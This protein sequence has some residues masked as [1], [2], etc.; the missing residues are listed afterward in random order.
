MHEQGPILLLTGPPGAGKTTVARLL[1]SQARRAVHLESD[2]FFHFIR[3]GYINPWRP[4][5]DQQNATVMRLIGEVA[6]GYARAGYFTIV[7]GIFIPGWFLE[8]V[9]DALIRSG[10]TV[11]YAVLR[12]PLAVCQARAADRDRDPLRDPTAVEQLWNAF[13]DLG[14]LERHSV[15][16][17][18]ADPAAVADLIAR[19]LDQ[20]RTIRGPVAVRVR[21]GEQSDQAFVIQMGRLACSLD[22]RPVPPSDDLAVGALLPAS[23]EQTVIAV[24]EKGRPI[25]AAWWHMHQPALLSDVSGAPL[26]ELAMGVIESERGRGIGSTLIEELAART[27]L[28]FEA[29]AANVHLLNPAVRLYIRTG[30]RVAGQGRGHYGVAMRRRLRHE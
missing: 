13:A 30:F 14:D 10:N 19:E 16:T 4:E 23:A 29:L 17:D 2:E 3:S 9:R 11:A 7:D 12:A 21:D 28:Q 25:G 20:L 8:P 27:A 22:G 18:G 1:A 15:A 26:P 24:N 6:A 5:A